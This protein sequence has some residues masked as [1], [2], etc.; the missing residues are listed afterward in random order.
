MRRRGRGLVASRCFEQVKN[1][2]HTGF[3]QL[4][5]ASRICSVLASL[6]LSSMRGRRGFA[7]FFFVVDE[8]TK[9][10]SSWSWSSSKTEK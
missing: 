2:Q 1:S 7:S 10:A 4:R 6:D 8:G 5:L 3:K 9:E